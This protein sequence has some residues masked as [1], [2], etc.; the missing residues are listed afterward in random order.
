MAWFEPGDGIGVVRAAGCALVSSQGAHLVELL[1]RVLAG[2]H[3]DMANVIDEIAAIGVRN[4]PSFALTVRDPAGLRLL[5]RGE[6]T[7][8]ILGTE[9]E[10]LIGAGHVSTW[11]EEVTSADRVLM[12]IGAS[13][14]PAGF[15]EVEAGIVP[16]CSLRWALPEPT[17]D[18][19]AGTATVRDAPHDLDAAATIGPAEPVLTPAQVEWV[20]S[21]DAHV[22]PS[23]PVVGQPPVLDVAE[24]SEEEA[25]ATLDTPAVEPAPPDSRVA[26][27][28]RESE[29]IP[30]A[31]EFD[32]RHLIEHTVYRSIEDAEVR[33]GGPAPGDHGNGTA[34]VTV[35]ATAPPRAP[36]GLIPPT[37]PRPRV[38]DEMLRPEHTA[39]VADIIDLIPAATP[40]SAELQHEAPTREL[41]DHDGHT[42]ARARCSTSDGPAVGVP[43]AR[44]GPPVQAVRCPGGH[45]NPPFLDQCRSCGA[46]IVD[47]RVDMVTR[48][49]LGLLRFDDGR[50]VGLDR[51]I[52]LGRKP[53]A[54]GL[55]NG[56]VPSTV[57]LDDPEQELSRTHVE[58]RIEEWQV[59]VVDRGSLNHTFVQV[60]G[61]QQRQLYPNDP[62]P[63]P[64]GTRI[65]LGNAVSCTFEVSS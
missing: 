60:P 20:E 3:P 30:D 41:G 42:V 53:V 25:T 49:Q 52:L 2:A 40:G 44:T 23:G 62:T 29:P 11:V 33:S 18:A 55:V 47:R 26:T 6:V 8:Q 31:D 45:A 56:E 28:P 17:L 13:P 59:V 35:D 61:Q 19:L 63:I 32:F 12:A 24:M 1:D 37:E 14:E 15:F 54:T 9:D 34:P 5:L 46:A 58:L 48:P 57:A 50:T 51:P 43:G 21:P 38:P 39:V 22:D 10:R 36:G 16:A 7:V 4:L 64:P 65:S 27:V